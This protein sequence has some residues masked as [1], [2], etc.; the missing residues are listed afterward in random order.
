M[1]LQKCLRNMVGTWTN[2]VDTLCFICFTTSI[3]LSLLHYPNLIWG[4]LL[5]GFRSRIGATSDIHVADSVSWSNWFEISKGVGGIAGMFMICVYHTKQEVNTRSLNVLASILA[6][7][8][9]M[10]VVS[11]LYKGGVFRLN[12]AVGVAVALLGV[13]EVW[14]LNENQIELLQR[15]TIAQKAC[16]VPLSWRYIALYSSWNAAFTYSANFSWSTRGMLATAVVIAAIVD[17]D[18]WLAARCFSLV[19]NMILRATETGEFYNPGRTLLTSPTQTFR[20][21]RPV[22]ITWV[23]LHTFM[24]ALMILDKISNYIAFLLLHQGRY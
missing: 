24:L 6:V 10:A 14:S 12:A 2:I 8:I 1:K 17:K 19:L 18:A 16:L 13:W 3:S 5:W 7:N 4:L 9:L 15:K 20:H 21:S 11:D 22:Y 23:C